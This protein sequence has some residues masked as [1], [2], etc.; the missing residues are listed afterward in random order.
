MV[1]HDGVAVLRCS[2]F[3]VH[4]CTNVF[5]CAPLIVILA[6][7]IDAQLENYITLDHATNRISVSHVLFSLF[8]LFA[9]GPRLEGAYNP[10]D[11]SNLDVKAE[12]RD[13]FQFITE[14]V[15]ASM[16]RNAAARLFGPERLS[17]AFDYFTFIPACLSSSLFCGSPG[18]LS[19]SYCFRPSAHLIASSHF[20]SFFQLWRVALHS[21]AI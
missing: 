11:F 10:S 16:L 6:V 3:C 7:D 18:P 15:H 14:Y 21:A 8:P 2:I 1:A 20:A 5:V 19:R 4:V 17:A 13:L 9:L 12:V